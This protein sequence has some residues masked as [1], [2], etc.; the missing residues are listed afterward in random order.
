MSKQQANDI[1]F[2]IP[3]LKLS[4]GVISDSS[5]VLCKAFSSSLVKTLG[6]SGFSLMISK[7]NKTYRLS[8]MPKNIDEVIETL[9]N[10]V[11]IKTQGRPTLEVLNTRTQRISYDCLLSKSSDCIFKMIFPHFLVLRLDIKEELDEWRNYLDILKIQYWKGWFE[12]I[13]YKNTSIKFMDL[14]NNSDI[15]WETKY[16]ILVLLTN[17][18]MKLDSLNSSTFYLLK[19]PNS[20]NILKEIYFS[21]KKFT[22]ELFLEYSNREICAKPLL[23]HQIA[24]KKVLITPSTV[25]FFPPE[26]E[27][28]N[29]VMR[30]YSEFSDYFLRVSFCDENFEKRVWPGNSEVLKRF[31]KI[32]S[33][34]TLFEHEFEFLGFSNSQMRS[35]SCWMV[36]KTLDYWANL[37]REDLGDFSSCKTIAKYTC[38]LGLCFTST[39]K[40]LHIPK[41]KII[42]ISEI[43]RNGYKF[44]DG[45]GKISPEFLLEARSMLEISPNDD[46]S[47]V[48][49]RLGGCKGVVVLAPELDCS[50]AIRP[51]MCK[52]YSED[53][54]LEVCSFAK[55]KPAYL[56][57]Q[58]ILL[59]HGLGVPESVFLDLQSNMISDAQ[60]SLENESLALEFIKQYNENGLYNDLVFMLQRNILIK[61][62][63]YLEGMLYSI[64]NN[65]IVDI[66]ER[67][68]IFAPDSSLL[69]GVMDEYAILN[70]QQVYI[71]ISAAG[72][73][74]IIAGKVV[75]AKNP[76]LHPG[77]V[78]VLEAVDVPE[79]A[80]LV[81]V[82]VFPQN[83]PRPHPNECSGSD[84]DGDEYFV[85]WNP[86]LIPP[87]TCK[88]MEYPSYIEPID[89][90]ISIE[91]VKD[92]FIKY[93][94][95]ENLGTIANLHLLYADLY[96]IYS[97][98]A[99]KLAY[100]H[101]QAV[102]YAKTGIPVSVPSGLKVTIWPDFMQKFYKPSYPSP[103]ILGKLYRSIII[104]QEI[105][106]FKST[107]NPKF[108][109]SGHENYL[110]QASNILD[111][112]KQ[113]IQTLL[114]KFQLQ[115]EFKLYQNKLC[116][117]KSGNNRTYV[118]KLTSQLKQFVKKKFLAVK[119]DSERRKLASAFYVVS[120]SQTE[121]VYTFPWIVYNYLL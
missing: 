87:S 78:R 112:Y 52:F 23:N 49:I 72:K 35:H 106:F 51:S 68:R 62:E 119:D 12:L 100:L 109:K 11:Y 92:Y 22:H 79:L 56:N 74:N 121:P 108:I 94:Q 4:T 91:K 93:M 89:N 39:Y 40:T 19:H 9:E 67:A 46:I 15:T 32:L 63:P 65:F 30:K 18:L 16:Y 8:I 25:S 7:K 70:N 38:R 55:W 27:I 115:N 10:S 58:I 98:Q 34:F 33:N 118:Y 24:I 120:Y 96:G 101:S 110:V 47:A 117:K 113:E 6:S 90:D 82:I 107:L 50:I 61:Q 26:I 13:S 66:K 36:L 42:K 5:F 57:R 69:V 20:S 60:K 54:S 71:R 48:Q 102:D 86:S 1:K 3:F 45:V 105:K 81:N 99:I 31:R 29:R 43:E 80:H 17:S 111:Y 83:G 75:I 77:D 53:T 37:I 28:G 73:S 104:N 103:G 95:S 41:E 88:S 59:L 97:T 114:R 14:F 44:S 76:C 84:L 116:N 85:S 2:K 64:Y 21:Y